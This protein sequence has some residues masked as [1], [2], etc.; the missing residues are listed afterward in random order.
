MK[1][2][3]PQ[4]KTA[5]LNQ[6][7]RAKRIDGSSIVT[8][9]LP[10]VGTGVR[11]DLAFLAKKRM[12]G[13]EIKSD[14][15]SLRRLRR[16]MDV[17]IHYFD[18]TILVLGETTSRKVDLVDYPDVEVWALREG[19]LKKVQ[20]AKLRPQPPDRPISTLF[21]K[22]FVETSRRFWLHVN[23]RT[24][25]TEDLNLLSRYHDRRVMGR[26]IESLYEQ[27]LISWKKA[28]EPSD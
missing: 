2:N 6:L 1:L 5:V 21:H 13:V 16:Q 17:Y 22:R 12:V 26:K 23:G 11:A 10:L 25:T 20:G 19:K 4:I 24:I 27:S 15:D 7:R 3:E 8:S 9:E 28:S 18:L 14:F